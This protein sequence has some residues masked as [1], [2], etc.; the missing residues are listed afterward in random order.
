[1]TY[2]YNYALIFSLFEF[3]EFI[4]LYQTWKPFLQRTWSLKPT[5][6]THRLRYDLLVVQHPRQGKR[7]IIYTYSC[8]CILTGN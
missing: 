6:I 5:P 8:Q 2:K 7:R 3:T 4:K 1:V